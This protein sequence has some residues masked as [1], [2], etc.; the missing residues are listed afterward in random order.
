MLP[1]AFDYPDD[2]IANKITDQYMFGD[3]LMVCP[4]TKPMYYLPGSK[5]MEAEET[6]KV[7]LPKRRMV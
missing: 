1:L 7:Y 6:R 5:K 2:A 3:S 4:V